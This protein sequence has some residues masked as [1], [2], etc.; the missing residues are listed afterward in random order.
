ML[1]FNTMDMSI[2][3]VT[4]IIL[5]VLFFLNVFSQESEPENQKITVNSFYVENI[6]SNYNKSGITLKFK[7]KFSEPIKDY[8]KYPYY[9]Q[10]KLEMEKGEIIYVNETP[11]KI[12]AKPSF[13]NTQV[14]EINQITVQIPYSEIDILN[15]K[16]YVNLELNFSSDY[17]DYGNI[18]SKRLLINKPYL[19]DY[20]EQTFTTSYIRVSTDKIYKQLKGINILFNNSLKFLNYETKNID[21]NPT[22]GDYY[23]KT[24]LFLMP[25]KEPIDFFG[26]SEIVYKLTANKKDKRINIHIPHNKINLAKGEHK[27]LI[28]VSATDISGNIEFGKI[29]KKELNYIQPKIYN[30]KV[31]MNLMEVNYSTDYDV[32]SAFGRAFSKSTSNKG[33]GY[34][35]V[36]WGVKAGEYIKY[37]SAA[38]KNSFIVYS[39]QTN[40]YVTDT[41]PLFLICNDRDNTSFDDFIGKYKIRNTKGDFSKKY[42]NIK[43]NNVKKADF[44]VSKIELPYLISKG[45]SLSQTKHKGISGVRASL[46]FASSTLQNEEYINVFPYEIN[47]GKS[48]II[49]DF[50]NLKNAGKALE[51]YGDNG[52]IEIFIPYFA[53]NNNSFLGFE[54]KLGVQNTKLAKILYKNAVEIPKVN[55]VSLSTS[56]IIETKKENIHGIELLLSREIPE[57][58]LKTE[59]KLLS[60]IRIVSKGKSII[61]TSL[62]IDKFNSYSSKIFIPYYKTINSDF[63]ITETV[64]IGSQNFIIGESSLN[65][66]FEFKKSDNISVNSIFIQFKDLETYKNIIVGLKYD[67]KFIYKSDLIKVEKSTN[68]IAN[69]Q[70]FKAYK[71]DEISIIIFSERNIEIYSKRIDISDLLTKKKVKLKGN[72]F[73]KKVIFD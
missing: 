6:S 32:K 9:M 40:F 4:I 67:N 55:D 62:I 16:H 69:L 12:F 57:Y 71:D 48:F 44:V 14:A 66:H 10:V 51:N 24:K 28:E 47:D 1:I 33:K 26:D 50:V 29:F 58:Y 41:D 65:Q 11:K 45:I 70:N 39:G 21:K 27:I 8:F 19:F 36:Y 56:K 37:T 18:F 20:E 46:N 23:I 25:N 7:V 63:K 53:L 34:P 49:S 15:G 43:F 22:L 64:T 2:K 35:D 73:I 68:I 13:N 72:G 3:K 61:D 31:T 17:K 30:L 60:K 42:R 52:K 59:D 54:L 38:N 5:Q